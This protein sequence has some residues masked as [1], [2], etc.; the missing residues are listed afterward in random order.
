MSSWAG[1]TVLVVAVMLCYCAYAGTTTQDENEE[2]LALVKRHLLRSIVAKPVS[3]AYS[4]LARPHVKTAFDSINEEARALK[5]SIE[6]NVGSIIDPERGAID[7]NLGSR[8]K[9]GAAFTGLGTKAAAVA[10][11]AYS[12]GQFHLAI[13]EVA[14]HVLYKGSKRPPTPNARAAQK[15]ALAA[16]SNVMSSAVVTRSPPLTAAFLLAGSGSYALKSLISDND[17]KG[18]RKSKVE[19]RPKRSA[20]CATTVST[21]LVAF[22]V[23]MLALCF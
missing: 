6:S 12:H 1:R 9:W 21:S 13:A 17:V 11:G 7:P 5:V 23:V 22:A 16:A 20:G 8:V 15:L 18:L 14:M 19:A 3:Q 2:S 10:T 4:S